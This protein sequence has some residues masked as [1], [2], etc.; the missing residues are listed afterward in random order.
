MLDIKN[1]NLSYGASHILFSISLKA[2]LGNVTAILGRNGVGKSSLLKAVMGLETI[3]SGTIL[4]EK[5]DVSNLG[6]AFR[7]RSGVAYV[8]QGREIFS[9]LT[10]E[11]NLQ[12]GF[13]VLPRKERKIDVCSGEQ[14]PQ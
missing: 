8:P 7:A 5:T 11:E 3:Q 12:T 10:V 1:I 2:K 13:S 9:L 6:P 4:W 14:C